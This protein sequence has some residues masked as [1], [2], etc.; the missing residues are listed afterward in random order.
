MTNSKQMRCL[1]PV[2]KVHNIGTQPRLYVLMHEH[3][4][5][6]EATIG[7]SRFFKPNSKQN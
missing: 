1:I 5:F 2:Y 6:W 4:E 7:K 3:L